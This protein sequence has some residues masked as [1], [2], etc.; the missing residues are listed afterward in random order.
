MTAFYTDTMSTET[1][2]EVKLLQIG[3]SPDPDDA[4]MFYGY[5]SGK[6]TIPG[7]EIDHVLG[8]GVVFR[9]ARVVKDGG[10]DH[11][12]VVTSFHVP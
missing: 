11:F 8:R 1:T 6:V 12:A 3:H 10:S 4:F 7:F 2:Q 5:G 9:D